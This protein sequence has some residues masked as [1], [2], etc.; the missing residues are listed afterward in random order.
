[1]VLVDD[2]ETRLTD[3][4]TRNL[5]VSWFEHSAPRAVEGAIIRALRPPLN[6]DHATGP[7]VELIK[8]ARRRYYDSAGPRPS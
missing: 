5:R 4:M 7:A 2:D 3:W 1:V 6:V 8:A